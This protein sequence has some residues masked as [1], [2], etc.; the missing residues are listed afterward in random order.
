MLH[1]NGIMKIFISSRKVAYYSSYVN[2]DFNLNTSFEI[3][4]T[5]VKLHVHIN[6][7]NSLLLMWLCSRILIYI[8]PHQMRKMICHTLSHVSFKF[9]NSLS[10]EQPLST[11]G[12]RRQS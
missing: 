8:L 2:T 7:L 9:G 5:V 11:E 4:K 3:C 10:L 12:I 6:I 1:T